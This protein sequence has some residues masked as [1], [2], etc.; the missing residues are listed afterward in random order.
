MISPDQILGTLAQLGF[1]APAFSAAV[2]TLRHGGAVQLS[3]AEKQGYRFM[4]ALASLLVLGSVVPFAVPADRIENLPWLVCGPA[5]GLGLFVVM[6]RQLTIKSS[7]PRR[8]WLFVWGFLL[9]ASAT[10][11]AEF[12]N[13]AWPSPHLYTSGLVAILGFL[14]IQFWILVSMA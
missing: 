9:P 10:I 4:L 1:A 5:I 12:L 2:T 3:P 6:V 7:A 14:S 11:V 8:R 13:L